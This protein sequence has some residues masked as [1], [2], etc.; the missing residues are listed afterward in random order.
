MKKTLFTILAAACL[1]GCGEPPCAGEP[2]FVFY[3]TDSTV[4]EVRGVL[5]QVHNFVNTPNKAPNKRYVPPAPREYV[6]IVSHE[7]TYLYNWQLSRDW[8]SWCPEG[9]IMSPVALG[10]TV[11]VRGTVRTLTNEDGNY[12]QDIIV[13]SILAITPPYHTNMY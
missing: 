11:R 12:F 8:K 9:D 2:E 5:E 6:A 4:C 3:A 7:G 13:D 10:D 1:I